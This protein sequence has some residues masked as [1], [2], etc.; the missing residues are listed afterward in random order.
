MPAGRLLR[1]LRPVGLTRHPLHSSYTRAGKAV[2]PQAG[3]DAAKEANAESNQDV[4]P[5]LEE[6]AAPDPTPDSSES[7]RAEETKDAAPQNSSEGKQAGEGR[8]DAPGP[9]EVLYMREPTVVPGKKHPPMPYTHYFDTYLMVNRLTDAGFKKGEAVTTMKAVRALLGAKME[10]AQGRLVSK[11]DVDNVSR[12]YRV[13]V[14]SITEA[15]HISSGINAFLSFHARPFI[16]LSPSL[17]YPS[18]SYK[19]PNKLPNKKQQETKTIKS[20]DSANDPFS[21]IPFSHFL[22]T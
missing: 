2:Q 11:G 18:Y 10:E 12:L 5:T 6:V 15:V 17:F 22:L 3:A 19:T 9:M 21:P 13:L 4:G 1:A 16:K 20:I 14:L 7:A 8:E